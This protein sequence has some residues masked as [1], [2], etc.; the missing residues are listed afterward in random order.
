VSQAVHDLTHDDARR[1]PVSMQ[2]TFG[3]EPCARGFTLLRYLAGAWGIARIVSAR[4]EILLDIQSVSYGTDGRRHPEYACAL[5]PLQDARRRARPQG[6][7]LR[8]PSGA[9]VPP[10]S[11]PL[12][13]DTSSAFKLRSTVGGSTAPRYR[14]HLGSSPSPSNLGQEKDLH[15][16][17]IRRHREATGHAGEVAQGNFAD[18][19]GLGQRGKVRVCPDVGGDDRLK[20]RGQPA[21]LRPMDST[22]RRGIAA[23][24]LSLAFRAAGLPGGTGKG[25]GGQSSTS[26]WAASSFSAPPLVGGLL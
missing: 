12:P 10:L 6:L 3:G 18:G 16:R 13:A 4:R 20:A 19:C 7:A 22:T 25:A 14:D 15:A 17:S 23:H 26:L 24:D 21:E 2:R 9:D 1:Y 11:V 5:M 8:R